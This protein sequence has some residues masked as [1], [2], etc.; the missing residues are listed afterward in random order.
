MHAHHKP[1]IER[2]TLSHFYIR[3]DPFAL[4]LLKYISAPDLQR[5]FHVHAY[6]NWVLLNVAIPSVPFL[7][8][9]QRCCGS[10]ATLQHISVRNLDEYVWW[11]LL[12]LL[13]RLMGER[14]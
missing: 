11:T 5:T 7:C 14:A 6:T 4:K 13:Q 8:R 12:L 1:L 9:S 2:L 10:V 3:R